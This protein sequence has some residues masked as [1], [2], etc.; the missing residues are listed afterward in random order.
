MVW[1]EETPMSGR[2]Q[3]KKIKNDI[4]IPGQVTELY[5]T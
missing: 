5:H 4:V 1:I 3:I 2:V